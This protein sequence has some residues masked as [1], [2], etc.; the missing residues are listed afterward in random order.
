MC[1]KIVVMGG[2]FNP[3]TVAHKALM[4]AAVDA[5]GADLGIFVP[6]SHA[7]VKKKMEKAT[8]APLLIDEELRLAMLRAMAEDDARLAVDDYEYH[9]TEKSRTYDTMVYLAEKH[10]DAEL[11]FLA[12]GDKLDIFPRWYRIGDF[13]ERF[14][15]IVTDRD[16]YDAASA[17]EENAFLRGY[18]ERFLV[19]DYPKGVLPV[20]SSAVREKWLAGDLEGAGA[21]LHPAVYDIMKEPSKYLIASFRE[22]FYFLSN[23]Y[24]A[25]VFFQGITYPNAEAA[26]QAQK[27]LTEEEKQLF[28]TLSP[29][30]AKSRGRKVAL[31]PDWEA[32]KVGLMEEIVYAKFAEN[33]ALKKLLLATGDAV[34]REGNT[35]HDTFW[36]VDDKTH[37]GKNHLG[38]IL[39]KVRTALR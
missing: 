13:L 5:V 24:E 38:K 20:S 39:M 23:F 2:S 34:L 15:I 31:R 30:E 16:D 1:K 35:W 14:R 4:L 22:N 9:I 7:Y 37:R 33:E 21:M 32:V 25:P 29:D 36:G 28:A 26:F 11:Y 12:G 3:P 27:C 18:R 19:I 6:S 8:S 10:P 17:L